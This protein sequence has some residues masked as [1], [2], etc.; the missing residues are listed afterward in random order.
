[1]FLHFAV[2]TYLHFAVKMHQKNLRYDL[3][4][5]RKYL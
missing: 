1:M 2:K 3:L 4:S 5:L